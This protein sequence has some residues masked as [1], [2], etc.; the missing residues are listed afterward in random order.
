MVAYTAIEVPQS[1]TLMAKNGANPFPKADHPPCAHSIDDKDPI[2]TLPTVEVMTLVFTTSRGIVTV[3]AMTAVTMLHAADW[4]KV[5]VPSPP[6]ALLAPDT[7]ERNCSKS[8]NDIAWRMHT[9]TC[10]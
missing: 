2:D 10:M 3:E 8:A 9:H 5:T 6:A 4:L 1:A 7:R